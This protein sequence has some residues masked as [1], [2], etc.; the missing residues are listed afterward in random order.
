MT[1]A[2]AD[3]ASLAAGELTRRS[4]LWVQGLGMFATSILFT[5]DASR[6]AFHSSKAYSLVY[7]VPGGPWTWSIWPIVCSLL[8]LGGM[9]IRHWK[10]TFIG[11]LGL[12]VWYAGQTTIVLINWN[13]GGHR[14]L[15][16]PVG[17]YGLVLFPKA[18]THMVTVAVSGRRD[19]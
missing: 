16:G 12:A 8:L 5:V 13:R 10:V 17:V 1:L 4:V 11:L 2:D 14:G 19:G 7:H 15:L 18:I 9:S 6:G 3:R